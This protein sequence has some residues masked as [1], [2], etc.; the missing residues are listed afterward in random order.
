MSIASY[1]RNVARKVTGPD[2]PVCFPASL[3]QVS[4]NYSYRPRVYRDYGE[5]IEW[6]DKI[7]PKRRHEN[8]IFYEDM[9]NDLLKP[10]G[11]LAC[12]DVQFSQATTPVGWMRVVKRALREEMQVVADIR[13][14]TSIYTCHSV[15]I[16]PTPQE[17]YVTLVSTHIPKPLQGI[18]P[19]QRVAERMYY[20]PA[21]DSPSQRFPFRTSNIVVLP[22]A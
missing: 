11:G 7:P 3:E 21:I 15:G 12:E 5:F 8:D 9:L 22:A 1:E 17:N 13:Y 20:I 19:L 14:C 6:W 16:L 2:F 4:S 10:L 18:V